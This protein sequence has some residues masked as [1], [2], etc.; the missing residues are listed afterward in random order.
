[1]KKSSLFGFAAAL[2]LASCTTNDEVLD[3]A[4]QTPMEFSSFVNKTTKGPL[5]LAGVQTTGFSVWGY[6]QK[7][8]GQTSTFITVFGNTPITW[9]N[10]KW[11]YQDP[12]RYWDKTCTYDFYAYAPTSAN[13]SIESP[14][15]GGNATLKVTS[16]TVSNNPAEYV[17]HTDLL[18]AERKKGYNTYT[19]EPVKFDFKHTLT[20]LSIGFTTSLTGADQT[21]VLKVATLKNVINN[22]Q[23]THSFTSAGND[24]VKGL[25]SPIEATKE[26][27][28]T[29]PADETKV[30]FPKQIDGDV[31]LTSKNQKVFTDLMMIPQP[32]SDNDL[33]SLYI[34]YTINDELFTNTI[35]L[36]LNEGWKANQSIV[37]NINISATQITFDAEV[38]KWDDDTITS[39]EG[40]D[41][42]VTP[43]I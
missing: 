25:W 34:E 40:W 1:M 22:R 11:I 18:I 2:T 17:S 5:D 19:K 9:A 41:K 20:K 28:D 43:A 12:T 42:P 35:D 26:G 24:E 39:P 7:T 29:T 4:V 31:T 38:S 13:V 14:S 15:A 32:S 6:K 10:Q 27:G 16:F 33:K 36:P 21:V 3:A 37:Y 30:N 8:V 23:Y